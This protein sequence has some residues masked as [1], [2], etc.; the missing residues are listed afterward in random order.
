[1]RIILNFSHLYDCDS[2]DIMSKYTDIGKI[3]SALI[4]DI[5]YVN[6]QE[7]IF[8]INYFNWNEY[9]RNY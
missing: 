2:V 7:V 6:M 3:P 5:N 4:T 8:K 1:M 9:R